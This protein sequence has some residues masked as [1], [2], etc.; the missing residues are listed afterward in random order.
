MPVVDW[1]RTNLEMQ[2]DD[3]ALALAFNYIDFAAFDMFILKRDQAEND[4]SEE[5]IKKAKSSFSSMSEEQ[6]Y[7][8]QKNIIAGLPGGQEGY[9]IESFRNKLSEYKDIDS[10]KYRQNLKY[11]LEQIIPVA[12]E[13]GVRWRFTP[14]IHRFHSLAFQ[15]WLAPNLTCSLSQI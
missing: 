3:G 8:L 15:E 12:M 13:S 11:F 14:M 2:L 1:T 10:E 9:D 7:I 6:K 4:Y 5:I